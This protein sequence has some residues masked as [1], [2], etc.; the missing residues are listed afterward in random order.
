[1]SIDAFG[2]TT[3]VLPGTAA[4]ADS[5][6][7][8]DEIAKQFAIMELPDGSEV[9]P[10]SIQSTGIPPNSSASQSESP[11]VDG[12]DQLDGKTGMAIG[13]ALVALAGFLLFRT[14]RG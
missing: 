14:T 11:L 7:S 6:L 13:I 10:L 1:M 3:Q 9:L 4:E 8:V 5:F 12:F 2:Q